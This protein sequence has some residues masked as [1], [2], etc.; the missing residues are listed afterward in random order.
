MSRFQCDDKAVKSVMKLEDKHVISKHAN[1]AVFS[2]V[3]V[4]SS[5]QGNGLFF[6][7]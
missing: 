1:G 2:L 5:R 6:G 3:N 4:M 7:K